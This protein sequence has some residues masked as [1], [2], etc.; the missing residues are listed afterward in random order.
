MA[1]PFNYLDFFPALTPDT[2][3]IFNK[4]PAVRL[5]A[6]GWQDSSSPE[7]SSDE[8][9]RPPAPFFMDLEI[10]TFCQLRCDYCARTFLD[11]APQHMTVTCLEEILGA[12]PDLVAVTLVGLGEPLMH[13]QL[14]E[15]IQLLKARGLR[16][17]LVTNGMALDVKK[18]K[19]L[20]DCQLNA[21]TFSLDCMDPVIFRHNRQGANVSHILE[22]I[23]QF[24]SLK[25][26]NSQQ[27]TANIFCALQP[28]TLNGL[29][30]LAQFSAEM[31]I[32][33]LVVSDLNFAH[34]DDRSLRTSE[35]TEKLSRILL[36][37]M[38]KVASCGVVLLSP[39][40]LDKVLA[41]KEWPTSR[42]TLPEQIIHRR[43][44]RHKQ[45]L[46]PWRTLV[47]RVDGEVNFCNCTPQ[48][49]A[50]KIGPTP[51]LDIWWQTEYQK[52]RNNLYNGPLPESCKS[53]PRL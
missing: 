14:F 29:G 21:I 3:E 53:C 11:V 27:I 13:P 34:N 47:V 9:C 18:S 39:N 30:Q 26:A 32:P 7:F 23:K 8:I 28:D 35:C 40:I 44:V 46:A 52:F 31:G 1:D 48:I 24:M 50:G 16:V 20:I 15:I 49:F 38:R 41:E 36:E 10:T 37:Q 51:F 25:K 17:S 43:S 42:I 6:A 33:A 45:C 22:N 5:S 2:L 4:S 12:G 19:M